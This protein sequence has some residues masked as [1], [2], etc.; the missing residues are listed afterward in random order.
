MSIAAGA[1]TLLGLYAPASSPSCDNPRQYVKP[2]SYRNFVG[3]L[4][5]GAD[6]RV[7]KLISIAAPNDESTAQ[8]SISF[9]RWR[10]QNTP[11]GWTSDFGTRW[12]RC[13]Q[14]DSF[15]TKYIVCNIAYW[16]ICRFADSFHLQAFWNG[17][18]KL[19]DARMVLHKV[20]PLDIATADFSMTFEP[21]D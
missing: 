6:H 18:C 13:S 11:N 5:V 19:A 1:V 16:H 2:G 17:I 14:G 4:L 3:A 10:N 8:K 20:T 21:L 15:P 9:A 7:P 12:W